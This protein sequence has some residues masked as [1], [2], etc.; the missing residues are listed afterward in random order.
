[1]SSDFNFTVVS[2]FL[3]NVHVKP[4]ST[5]IGG[6][7]LNVENGDILFSGGHWIEDMGERGVKKQGISGD[8]LY[9]SK[10]FFPTFPK[11]FSYFLQT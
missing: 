10:L 9:G 6:G 2:W 11:E 1:M 8:V 3:G 4:I 7:G 5:H